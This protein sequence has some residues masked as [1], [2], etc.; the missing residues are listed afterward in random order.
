MIPVITKL[1][2]ATIQKPLLDA[3]YVAYMYVRKRSYTIAKDLV[4]PR[5]REVAKLYWAPSTKENSVDSIMYV[6]I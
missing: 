1:D 5:T 6:A 4:K 2:T 3:S